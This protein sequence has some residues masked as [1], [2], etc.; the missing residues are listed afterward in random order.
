MSVVQF[1]NE[2]NQTYNISN[3][4]Q[5]IDQL[6]KLLSIN[7]QQNKYILIIY[8]CKSIPSTITTLYDDDWPIFNSILINF[9]KLC[10]L[11]DPW[12]L[13]KSFDLYINYLNDLSIG[14][15][16]NSYGW[17]L[18]NIITNTI[19][20][21]I[22]WA[23]KLDLIMY[24]KE[25]GG[26]FRL[27]Y[28]AGIIL[29]IFNNNIIRINDSN[30]YK[31]SILLILGNNLCYIYFKLDKPLLC[32]NIFN[33]MRNIINLNFN[34]FNLN[35]QLKYRYYLSRYYLIKYQLI[36]SFNHLQW[37]LINTTNFKN[38]KLIL[39]LL[40]PI[41]LIVGKIP[42]FNYLSENG[43]DDDSNNSN[44]NNNN[45]NNNNFPFIKMYQCLSKTIITGNYLEFKQLINCNSKNYHYL[46][47]KNLLLLLMNKM[48][49][50]LLRNLIKKIWIILNK[51]T[52][53][54]YLI[55]PIEGHYN[56]E[57]YLE[58]VFVTLIDSNLIKGKL[59]SSKTVVLSKTD[60]FPNVFNIYKLKYGNNNNSNSN[61]WI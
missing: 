21:M 24:F 25:K 27:N 5:K 23:K 14:F 18:S 10:H 57:L 3:N 7:P 36:E 9:I 12:S 29:K 60:P 45:N 13:L 30:D 43:F 46:K 1:I 8:N 59:T 34:Q 35:Q 20:L 61:Q 56:D 28:M 33:N 49:I 52:T 55:I 31:K 17:L 15:N 41:S 37:C 47:D 54:N 44:N 58:N 40:L 32:Q 51:P 38:Q 42:N 39:E 53:M 26:K 4:Q 22:P 16:N 48:E 11:M 2:I 50:L 19:N 6:T